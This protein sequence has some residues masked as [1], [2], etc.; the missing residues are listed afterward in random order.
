[1]LQDF[2]PSANLC[3]QIINITNSRFFTSDYGWL[4]TLAVSLWWSSDSN[5]F[6]FILATK[7]LLK[8]LLLSIVLSEPISCF[9]TYKFYFMVLHTWTN[10]NISNWIFNTLLSLKLKKA[11]L[12]TFCSNSHH[13]P[14]A[15]GMHLGTLGLA[16]HVSSAYNMHRVLSKPLLCTNNVPPGVPI[17]LPVFLVLRA[18]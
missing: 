2:I 11:F 1:L 14:D 6:R 16:N 12:N 8:I 17:C 18:R 9:K 4:Q 15:Y 10:I 7:L 13:A 5:V 3:L